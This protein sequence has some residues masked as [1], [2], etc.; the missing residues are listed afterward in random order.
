HLENLFWGFLMTTMIDSASL[1]CLTLTS[2]LIRM[3]IRNSSEQTLNVKY[4][5]RETSAITG[6][7]LQ[8]GV[9]SLIAKVLSSRTPSISSLQLCA[10]GFA[11]SVVYPIFMQIETTNCL[12]CCTT[13]LVRHAGFRRHILRAIGRVTPA[14]TITE[15][16]EKTVQQMYFSELRKA[17]E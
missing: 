2:I 8:C 3:K 1:V 7:M 16:S 10:M 5:L 4:Q 17:W 15:H 13:L 14:M 12:I 9:T 11:W 6:V